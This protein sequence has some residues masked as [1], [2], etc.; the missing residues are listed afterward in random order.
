MEMQEITKIAIE[1][2]EKKPDGSWMCIK[3]SD[4]TTKTGRIVRIPPGTVFTKESRFCG[5]DVVA[6]LDA[7]SAK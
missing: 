6:A 5:L 1:E 3:N 4:I 7:I 2:Y